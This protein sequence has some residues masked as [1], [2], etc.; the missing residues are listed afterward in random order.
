MVADDGRMLPLAVVWCGMVGWWMNTA[1]ISPH[2][3]HG[4][5]WTDTCGDTAGGSDQ[6]VSTM[7]WVVEVVVS[8]AWLGRVVR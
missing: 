2:G 8:D 3:M 4:G 7:G 5:A 6:I 1:Y